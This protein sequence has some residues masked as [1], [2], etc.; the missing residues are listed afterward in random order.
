MA[1]ISDQQLITRYFK[2]DQQALELLIGRY[3]ALVYGSAYRYVKNSAE[4]ED[5]A[6]EVFIKMWKNLRRFDQTRNFKTWLLMITK[7][8]AIDWC[9]RQK[10]VPF[11]DFDQADGDN[12]LAET[13]ADSRPLASELFDGQLLAEQLNEAV[14]KLL[15]KYQAVFNSHHSDQLTFQE[16]A[17]TSGE[18]INTIKSRYRRAIGYLRKLL[19]D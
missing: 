13:L 16:I 17:V 4:A 18:S 19:T 14:D 15:P 7:Y 10:T 12:L 2:G 5:I 1:E 8:T 9:R 11:S 6:Q 3:L